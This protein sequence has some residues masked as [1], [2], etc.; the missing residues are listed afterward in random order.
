MSKI[1]L[2]LP[3]D[4]MENIPSGK[5]EMLE[6]L[7]KQFDEVIADY[8]SSLQRRVPGVLG[9]PI[10]RYERSL[11]KDFLIDMTIGKILKESSTQVAAEVLS[12]VK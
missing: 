4:V 1:E 11:L 10:S 3:D 2:K 9:Q 12:M 6:Y 7:S 5:R 8:D